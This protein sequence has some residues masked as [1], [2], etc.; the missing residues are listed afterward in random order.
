[1]EQGP[2]AELKTVAAILTAGSSRNFLF[3]GAK[4]EI[5]LQPGLKAPSGEP[6]NAI[7]TAYR[8][9]ESTGFTPTLSDTLLFQHIPMQPDERIPKAKG[10][11]AVQASILL[12]RLPE[13]QELRARAK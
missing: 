8:L 6:L 4:L 2:A 9:C 1:M 12:R 3:L 11:H 10:R 13:S 7:A 5:L